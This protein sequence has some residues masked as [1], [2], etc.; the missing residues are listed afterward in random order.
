M[1]LSDYI[2]VHSTRAAA[3][4]V[5]LFAATLVVGA[6]G[7]R[8]VKEIVRATGLSGT[9]RLLG[10]VFGAVRGMVIVLVVIGT[11][12]WFEIFSLDEWWQESVLI[13]HV[14]MLED[15]SRENAESLMSQFLG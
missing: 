6:L 1:L 5:L 7:S 2:P 8:L 13:P 15:W 11:L 10:M 3:S 14:M 4:F 12:H 9:D